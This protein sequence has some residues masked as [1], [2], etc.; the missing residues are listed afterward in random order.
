MLATYPLVQGRQAQ[1]ARGV[2]RQ[3]DERDSGR[4]DDRRIRLAGFE[5]GSWQ[6]VVAPAGTPRDVVAQAS[7]P[8]S[9]ASCATPEM[10]DNLGNQGADVRTNTRRTNSR[11][12]SAPKK[13]KWAKVVKD[14]DVKV[15]RFTRLTMET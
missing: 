6:G 3:A 7:T 5:T 13:T 15:S 2:E 9:G 10:R 12:S 11:R 4:A 14:A 8:R 1:A